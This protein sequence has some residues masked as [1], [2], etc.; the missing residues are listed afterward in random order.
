MTSFHIVILLVLIVEAR[1]LPRPMAIPDRSPWH[2]LRDHARASA[3]G[4]CRLDTR[5]WAERGCAAT[6]AARH[7]SSPDTTPAKHSERRGSANRAACV[8]AALG[9]RD[10]AFALSLFPG[11]LAGASDRFGFFA[12]LACGR[13]F[14]SLATL[15]L[16]KN[17]FA[18]HP[19]LQNPQSLIDIVVA[20][21]YLQMLSSRAVAAC[22]AS[23]DVASV[24][25]SEP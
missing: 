23:R 6:A 4:F 11:R 20:N 3:R 12:G 19:L 24:A 8:L 18:L 25:I 15:H 5:T 1:S 9:G 14:I 21:E 7:F 10:Q 17:A 16:A 13:L 22:A 2:V